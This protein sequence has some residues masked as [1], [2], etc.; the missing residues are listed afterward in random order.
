MPQY[1]EPWL[2]FQHTLVRQLAFAIASPNLICELP[3]ALDLQHVFQLHDDTQWYQHYHTYLPRLQQLD[4]DPSELLQFMQRL[5]STRLGLRFEYLM[6]FWLQDQAYHNLKL[7]A[8]GLQII[9]GK[10]TLGELDFVLYN[11]VTAQIEH[12]EVALKYYL[13]EQDLAL[14]DW[15][16]LNRSDTLSRKL[17]HFTR[18]QFQFSQLPGYVIEQKYAVMKGQ[19]Y[20]PHRPL[21]QTEPTLPVWVNPARRYG[22]WGEEMLSPY[23][24]LQRYEWIC[25][26]RQPSSQQPVWWGDGLYLHPASNHYYMFR[27]PQFRYPYV[28]NL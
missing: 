13:A 8:H 11:P 27:M 17:H 23:Y 26:D 9:D 12:W 19:L 1:F 5:K 7:L 22:H 18:K 4:Q 3:A 10:N 14:P 25:P 2:E 20:L 21:Q 15:Y 6:W 16:G 28:T 24:R